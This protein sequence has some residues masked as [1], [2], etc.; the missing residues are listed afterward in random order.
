MKNR[1]EYVKTLKAQLDKWNADIALWEAKAKAAQAG[2]HVEYE[3]Q[4]EA[5]RRQRD[6]SIKK[7]QE[8]QSATGD[9]WKELARGSDEAWAKM[10][11]SFEK[12]RSHFHKK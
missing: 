5:V 9:A 1:D 8:V 2:A 11:E 3:K 7:M 4:L 6:V 10:R 12:A